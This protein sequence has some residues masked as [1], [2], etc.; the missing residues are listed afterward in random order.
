MT[1]PSAGSTSPSP[2][3]SETCGRG[4]PF[5]W[6]P[7]VIVASVL[8]VAVAWLTLEWLQIL[9]RYGPTG[10]GWSTGPFSLLWPFGFLLFFL[11]LFIL[12]RFALWGPAHRWGSY[13]EGVSDSREVLRRRYA[14]GEI[15]REDFHRMW[16]DLEGTE[17]P[18]GP[19]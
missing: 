8:V 4:P 12:L 15:S 17:G 18:G 1:L 2:R 6:T 5:G 14:Q 16:R 7:V 10:A 13:S 11:T 9:P 19:R 3:L